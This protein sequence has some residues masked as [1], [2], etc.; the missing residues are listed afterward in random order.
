MHKNTL[1]SGVGP[2]T[3]GMDASGLHKTYTGYTWN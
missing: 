1:G 2:D 3:S